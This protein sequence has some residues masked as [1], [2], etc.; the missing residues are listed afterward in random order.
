MRLDARAFS[1]AG[2]VAAAVLFIICALAVAIAPGPTTAFA[3]YL[4]HTD[5][6]GMS[7]SLTVGSFVGGLIGWAVGTSLTFGLVAAVY[8]RLVGGSSGHL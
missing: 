4:I 3:G 7:R 6:S 1:L 8:N 5:L 2:G